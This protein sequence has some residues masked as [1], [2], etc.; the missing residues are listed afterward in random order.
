LKKVWMVVHFW[1]GLLMPLNK[2][3]LFKYKSDAEKVYEDLKRTSNPAIEQVQ[4]S[5]REVIILES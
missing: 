1:G 5:H 3:Y 2:I 4:L